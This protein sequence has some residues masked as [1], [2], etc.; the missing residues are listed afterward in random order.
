[1]AEAQGYRGYIASLPVR[2]QDI[3][4]QVQN[5]VVRDYCRRNDLL[6]LLS[7]TEYS[8]SNCFMMLNELM[9]SLDGYAGIVLFSQFQLP[10]KRS[11]RHEIYRRIIDTGVELHAALENSVVQNETDL[12]SFEDT[13]LV[14]NA[15]PFAPMEGRYDKT[16]MTAA[17]NKFKAA[18]LS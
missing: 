2:G 10:Q 8:I 14:A 6:F 4:H 17:L 3:P 1:M 5:M 13:I 7:A 16:G 11:D 18:A 12:A 9:N 15:L